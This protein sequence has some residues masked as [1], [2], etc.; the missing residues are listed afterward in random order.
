MTTLEDLCVIQAIQSGNNTSK[1]DTDAG[2]S[3]SRQVV[4]LVEVL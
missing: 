2:V 4:R 1:S 3:R